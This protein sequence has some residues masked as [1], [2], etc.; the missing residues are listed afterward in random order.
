[1]TPV[2]DLVYA[3]LLKRRPVQSSARTLLVGTGDLYFLTLQQFI[4]DGTDL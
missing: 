3:P 2:Y 1:M 4:S